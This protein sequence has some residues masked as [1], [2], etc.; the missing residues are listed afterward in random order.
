MKIIT[1][2]IIKGGSGKTT[3]CAALAQAAAAAGKKVLAVDLDPQASFT[4]TLG[5]DQN[6][7]GAVELLHGGEPS[8]L[9]QHT[10][11][12]IDTISAAP[13]LA[14]E[15]TKTGS[16]WRLCRILDAIKGYDLM[17]VDTPPTLGELTYNGLMA[18]T[19]LI[20]PLEAD[21]FG[22]QGL[23]QICD[24][25]HQM[26][27]NGARLQIL[28]SVITRYDGRSKINRYWHDAIATQGAEAGAPLLAEIRPG[29][30]VKE[31]QALQRSLFDYAP[32]SKPAQDYLALY[33]R[34]KMSHTKRQ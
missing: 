27:R 22:L 33:K 21:T 32:K 16:A 23:Y 9:I 12:K 31:A 34:L 29:V 18:A 2:A 20:I 15:T 26:Q 30:A 24:I 7:P 5:A 13:D 3:T 8:E 25:A 28:G 4:A 14:A 11:Q 19:G 17:I 6:R 1:A 10:A